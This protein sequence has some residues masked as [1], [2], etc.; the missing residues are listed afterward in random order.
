MSGD[1]RSLPERRWVFVLE[2]A[3]G[4]DLLL[5]ALSPF[6]VQGAEVTR[7][8]LQTVG[9]LARLEIETDGLGAKRAE[10]L[11]ARLQ[12]LAGVRSVACGWR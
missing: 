9:G 6:P 10:H 1:K 3:T 5:R 7:L 2:M 12:A 11:H 4:G 8:D